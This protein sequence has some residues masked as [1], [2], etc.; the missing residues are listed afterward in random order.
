MW[1]PLCF[2]TNHCSQATKS[3]RLPLTAMRLWTDAKISLADAKV[4]HLYMLG[5]FRG[6]PG[7]KPKWIFNEYWIEWTVI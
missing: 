2:A 6:H 7:T 3:I 4:P 1:E 5:P